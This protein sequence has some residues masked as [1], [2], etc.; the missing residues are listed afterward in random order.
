MT[1]WILAIDFGTTHT[2]SVAL[3]GD[4]NPEVVEIDGE[5]R[6][7]STVLVLPD[8]GTLIG[9][10][11][12]ALSLSYPGGTLRAVKARLGNSAPIILN[13]KPHQVVTLVATYLRSI[14]QAVI[15]QIGS[16]PA[17]VRL[18]HPVSW[19]RPLRQR[20]VEAAG[21][22]GLDQVVLVA[23]PVAAA[24]AYAAD[25]GLASGEHVAIYDLGGG[26]FDCAI[27]RGGDFAVLGQGSGDQNIGG[28][29]FD[30]LMMNDIGEQLDPGVWDRIQVADDPVWLRA[31]VGLRNEAR[32]AK[33][34]LSNSSAVD[35]FIALPAGLQ[36]VGVSRAA[37][38][39]L[40]RP[41][42]AESVELMRRCIV[43]AGLQPAEVS[44]IALIGG[45]SR[46]PIVSEMVIAAFP[47]MSVSRR[48]DP[49]ASVALGA[50][51]AARPIA[52]PRQPLG[53][54]ITQPASP[55]TAPEG[56]HLA[57]P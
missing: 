37:F 49:K 18:T 51:M 55:G 53:N 46:S 30:E 21:K 41:Y 2:V 14:S 29:L 56:V 8:G 13:G 1:S 25:A 54:R 36:Q 6:V 19:N 48:G 12:E 34:A 27:L 9:H 40:A 47:G 50:A 16:P 44:A 43:D 52:L 26:T 28:E 5:R 22:A 42:I 17:E 45:A 23:E 39:A 33:E 4:R 24:V 38:E 10:A 32:K 3:V 7:P 35:A 11:A 57:P 20:L 15:E 31:R